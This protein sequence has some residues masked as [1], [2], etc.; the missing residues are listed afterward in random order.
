MLDEK[1]GRA[2]TLLVFQVIGND[3]FT[4]S[5]GVAS[6][7]RQIGADTRHTDYSLVPPNARHNLETVFL[8]NMAQN[9]TELDVQALGCKAR[10]LAQQIVESC[11]L[12]GDHAEFRKYLLLADTLL[13]TPQSHA[14]T[15][16]AGFL[17]NHRLRIGLDHSLLDFLCGSMERRAST[18]KCKTRLQ[19]ARC[20]CRP[21]DRHPSSPKCRG[22]LA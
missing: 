15:A 6:R 14:C 17:F 11:A 19:R 1:V 2:K 3:R 4:R 5:Q 13:K 21:R 20:G 16:F 9:F 8:G 18:T 7:R 22:C 12:Q 10:R